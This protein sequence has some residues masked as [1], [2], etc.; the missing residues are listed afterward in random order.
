MKIALFCAGI[1]FACVV[2]AFVNGSTDAAMAQ[3]QLT[4]SY[5]ACFQI[6]NR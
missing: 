3:C 2:L 1:I 4:H 5:D 6:L